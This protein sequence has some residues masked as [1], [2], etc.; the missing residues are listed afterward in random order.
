MPKTT[1]LPPLKRADGISIRTH[2]VYPVKEESSFF[3]FF[4]QKFIIAAL[5]LFCGLDSIHEGNVLKFLHACPIA[6]FNCFFRMVEFIDLK[7]LIIQKNHR[8]H[9]KWDNHYSIG[10]DFYHVHPFLLNINRLCSVWWV[11][12]VIMSKA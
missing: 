4:F 11:D 12:R 2:S 5:E 3:F 6:N 8:K 7:I 10:Y 9:R 1:A